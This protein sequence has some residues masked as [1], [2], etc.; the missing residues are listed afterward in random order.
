MTTKSTKIT[1]DLGAVTETRKTP[2]PE[3]AMALAFTGAIKNLT[4][5]DASAFGQLPN[6][7]QIK[8]RFAAA[9]FPDQGQRFARAQIK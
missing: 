1:G 7:G 6:Q 8:R 3:R 9:A 2:A 5:V 4:I